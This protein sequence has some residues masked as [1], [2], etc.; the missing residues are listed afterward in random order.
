[1]KNW[2]GESVVWT[3]LA[4]RGAEATSQE[5]RR[6]NAYVRNLQALAAVF[7]KDGWVPVVGFER[8]KRFFKALEKADLATKTA[9]QKP[10][11]IDRTRHSKLGSQSRKSCFK[12]SQS[13]MGG[14]PGLASVY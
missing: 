8:S 14:W 9:T 7:P 11:P 10:Q 4:Q 5:Q 13:M 3:L 12:F 1:M 6:Q 2:T